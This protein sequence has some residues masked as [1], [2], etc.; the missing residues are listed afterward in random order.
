MAEQPF[1]HLHLHSEYS[2]LDGACRTKDIP[3]RAA[4]LGMSAIAV[5]DHGNMHSTIEFYRAC[6]DADIKPIIGMEAYVCAHDRREKMTGKANTGHLVL[7]ARNQTGYRNLLKLATEASLEGFYYHPRLDHQLLAEHAEGLIALTACIG[8][9]IPKLI[10]A[11]DMEQAKSL[12]CM[13]QEL[14]GADG[15]Y[16]ELQDHNTPDRLLYPDQPTLNAAMREISRELGIP[17]V[18]TNDVHYLQK[19]DFEAHEVLLCIGMQTT[20][21][22][23][24]QKGI[25]YSTEHYLKSPQEMYAFFPEDREG[26]EN[27][28]KIAELCNVEI[29]LDNPQLP[30]YEVPETY[31]PDSYLR[32]ICIQG[33]DER[34]TDETTRAH[35]LERLNYE[36][37]VICPKGLATYFLIV[38]DFLDWARRHDI[39]VGIRGSGAG[40]IVSYLTGISTV[41]P[42]EYTLW[43]ERFLSPDR[44]SMPDIDCDFE[45]RR[46][47][48][49]IQYVVSKYGVDHVAQVATF[50]TLQPRLAVRD[51]ARALGIPLPV[52]DRLAKAI[53]MA[54]TVQDAIEQN[55][56]IREWYEAEPTTRQLLD[57]AGKLQGLARHVGTHAAAVLIGRDPLVE[58]APLQR[59]ADGS[60]I[61]TQWEFP[62]AEAA[63]LVKMDFLGLRTLT[64]LKDTLNLVKNN[65][66]KTYDLATLPLDD[67]KAYEL[68]ARG[69]TGGVYQFESVGMR[70]ALRQLK[71]DRI[72]D[73][74]AMVAL[75][76]PGP[77]AE[78]PKFCQGKHNPATIT[79]LHPSLE[80]IL[81]ET[82]GVL[83][84]Q[85]QVM[86]IGKEIA[87]LNVLEANDL[88]NALRKKKLDKMAKLEPVFIAGAKKTSGF[89]DEQAAALWDRLKEFAKYAFNKA[90]SACYAIVAYQTAFLKANYPVEFMTALLTSVGDSQEKVGLYVAESQRLGI[91]VLP[92]DIN[93][94]RDF[95]TI[96][97]GK[98]RFGMAAIKGVGLGAVEA[99]VAAREADGSFVDLFDFCC[100]VESTQCNRL[101]LEALIK[102]GAFDALPGNR[103]QKLAILDSAIDMGQAAARDKAAGQISLFGE[104]AETAQMIVPELP[105]LPEYPP[106]QLLGM[107]RE[108]LGLY[109][110]DHPI[111]AHLEML[112]THRTAMVEELPETR[113][114]EE[115]II[116]GMLTGA[117]PYTAK[118]G[119]LMGFLTLDDLTGTVEITAFSD[120]FDKYQRFLQVDQILLV[121]GTLD[122]GMGRTAAPSGTEEE[123]DKPEP[124]ILMIAAAPIDDPAAIQ[125]MLQTNG[126]RRNSYNGNGHHRS[127][128]PPSFAPPEYKPSIP[129]ARKP[130]EVVEEIGDYSD[131]DA[132]PPVV[133]ERPVTV[134]KSESVEKCPCRIQL[135]EDFIKS[136]QFDAFPSLLQG[137]KGEDTV[138][139]TIK[140]PD[141]R[142]RR[143]EV[144]GLQVDASRIAQFMRVIPGVTIES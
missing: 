65:H 98:I 78:I 72:T 139:L 84:Y 100:R 73:V 50:G 16:L 81:V 12:C 26:L 41:D 130:P 135:S 19:D 91:Q 2:L 123:D 142:L 37:E 96:E 80:P 71:P 39:L 104:I 20:L 51:A 112:T 108:Y 97:D 76:R 66:G 46:R 70:N 134:E 101:A 25:Q 52:A 87:G 120:A 137:C 5:T 92:P 58:V 99:I 118:N 116:G 38:R 103:A 21:D 60:G 136:D 47:A 22:E 33:L 62:M 86:V 34:Y 94:S 29:E 23:Y 125:E 14:F 15:F 7:L 32:E 56:Q 59:M 28:A 90:H 31:T 3:Q 119:K 131:N 93:A 8:G 143:W 111:N 69:D 57:M 124:K 10:R 85:E 105:P 44:A 141:G 42:L 35:A 89:N 30:V 54:K 48:D 83:T 9:E 74:I 127:S 115:V 113:E 49:V 129:F 79:Y 117:K 36:L 68:M 1:I 13:Y 40:A 24:R 114:G 107:E 27:T 121:K 61:Q 132:P 82:N 64:V 77:M 67:A 106:Q 140:L 6:L 102:A 110:S 4:R 133:A 122:F 55:P 53:G 17:T 109:I 63:G 43:F 138:E 45:D 11:G 75:Y 128:Q 144:T 18:V 126:R 88:L 95:F